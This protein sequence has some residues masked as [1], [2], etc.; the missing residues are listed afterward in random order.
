MVESKQATGWV[1]GQCHGRWC[2]ASVCD[3]ED[4]AGLGWR[5]LVDRKLGMFTA[6]AEDEKEIERTSGLA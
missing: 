3:G 6:D 1:V 5:K 2:R 4:V